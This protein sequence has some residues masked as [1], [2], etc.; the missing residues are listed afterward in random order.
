MQGRRDSNPQPPV[1]ETGAL[2][3]EPLPYVRLCGLAHRLSLHMW[4]PGGLGACLSMVVVNHPVGEH[5]RGQR[6]NAN[7]ASSASDQPADLSG[8]AYQRLPTSVS[9]THLTLPTIYSV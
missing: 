9:Y 8:T 7:S 3:I 6:A 2:P 1:L 4:V 5:T